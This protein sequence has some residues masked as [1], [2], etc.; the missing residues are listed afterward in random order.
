MR[1]FGT[2]L[3][4][5]RL[6]E[7]W[8]HS[9]REIQLHRRPGRMWGA[10]RLRRPAGKVFGM[11]K[12]QKRYVR[13]GKAGFLNVTSL[14]DFFEVIHAHITILLEQPNLKVLPFL[15]NR[16]HQLLIIPVFI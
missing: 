1:I 12:L 5:T 11:F 7:D 8:D 16:F 10:P 14:G 9:S 6:R 15:F 3:D 4:G 2:R 13:G